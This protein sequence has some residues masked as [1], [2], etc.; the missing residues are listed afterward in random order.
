MKIVPP[1]VLKFLYLLIHTLYTWYEFIH[2]WISI[3]RF[4]RKYKSEVTD[5]LFH[6]VGFLMNMSSKLRIPSSI[7]FVVSRRELE[8]FELLVNKLARLVH[9]SVT[10]RIKNISIF[11]ETGK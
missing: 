4:N 3:I 11:D 8:N 5:E 6:Q 10:L 2:D 1:I 9:W 7:A